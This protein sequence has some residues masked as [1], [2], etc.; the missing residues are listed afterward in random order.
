MTCDI[1]YVLAGNAA[2]SDST[3]RIS[4]T[5]YSGNWNDSVHESF[6]QYV[7]DC[8][9]AESDTRLAESALRD[10]KES[11]EDLSSEETVVWGKQLCSK[12]S[13]I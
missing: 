9:S 13:S 7:K 8:K 2:F 12:I 1:S 10:A 4:E 3:R 6:Y 11:I 5:Y